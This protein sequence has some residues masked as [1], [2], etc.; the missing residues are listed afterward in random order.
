MSDI[1]QVAEKTQLLPQILPA[2]ADRKP[3]ERWPFPRYIDSSMIADW[4]ACEMKWAYNDMMK[5]QIKGGNIHLHAGNA[6]ARGL[7]VA[8]KSFYQDNN[9][10]AEAIYDGVDALWQAYGNFDSG[11]HPKSVDRMAAA[12][13]AYFDLW[14]L[15]E[16]EFVPAVFGGKP[17]IEFNFAVP[18]DIPHPETGDP[19]LICGRYDL[20]AKYHNGLI[21]NDDKTTG[22]NKKLEHWRMRGQF[23]CYNWAARQH[24]LP[25]LI[26]F[27]VRVAKILKTDIQLQQWILP[28]QEWDINRWY[29]ETLIIIERMIEAWR[30]QRFI[31]DMS[32]SCEAYNGCPYQRLCAIPLQQQA[33]W[34]MLDYERNLWSPVQLADD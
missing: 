23:K 16:D 20:L 26:G 11:D 3:V 10:E 6:F 1:I 9:S 34:I 27:A 32:A 33:P 19:L 13:V 31:H 17:A 5:I 8:R 30:K 7:E 28:Q 22:I 24:N 21:G 14:R 25:P 29:A 15:G 18:I 2:F 4:K 12:L